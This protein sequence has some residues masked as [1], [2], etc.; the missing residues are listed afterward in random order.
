MLQGLVLLHHLQHC[1]PQFAI[2]GAEEKGA[3]RGG[4]TYMHPPLQQPDLLAPA[5]QM[6]GSL[7]PRAMALQHQG[8]GV[9]P[10]TVDPR[11]GQPSRGQVRKSPRTLIPP[12]P[13]WTWLT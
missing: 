12:A 11:S 13:S 10:V 6:E 5:P 3:R 9:S 2:S 7:T 4:G 8:Q 1:P